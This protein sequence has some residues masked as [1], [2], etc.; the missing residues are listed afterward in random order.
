MAYCKKCGN[1]LETNS[2]FCTECGTKVIEKNTT[3]KAVYDGKIHKCPNCG[4][5][6]KSFVSI[7]PA[8]GFELNE[9]KV[10]EALKKFI[11]EVNNCENMI[12]NNSNIHNGWSLW[13]GSK[14]FWWIILNICFLC[15]PLV[16]YLTLPL[17]K[18]KFT[19]KL[20]KEEKQME[21]LVENFPFPNDRESIIAALIFVKEKTD[22]ISKESINRKNAYWLR[23][24]CSKAEQA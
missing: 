7:C 2:D 17:V 22:F 19:P 8:C 14:R 16:I 12:A 5:V 13:S 20:T 24:W 11:D 6:L 21:S 10:A 15:I 1:E 23:L 4:E 18:I 9:K 3:R